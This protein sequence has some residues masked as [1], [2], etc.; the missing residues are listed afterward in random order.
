MEKLKTYAKKLEMKLSEYKSFVVFYALV[1]NFLGWVLALIQILTLRHHRISY[2]KRI[3]SSDVRHLKYIIDRLDEAGLKS[4][5]RRYSSEIIDKDGFIEYKTCDSLLFSSLY[6]ASGMNVNIKMAEDKL[7]P[8]RWYRR[9]IRHNQC[10][11]KYSKSTI[12]RDMLIGLMLGAFVRGEFDILLNLHRYGRKNLWLMGDGAFT[13]IHLGS[14]LESTLALCLMHPKF[15]SKFKGLQR[16][17]RVRIAISSWKPVTYGT[18]LKGY[19]KHLLTLHLILRILVNGGLQKAEIDA[20]VD[21]EWGHSDLLH[22]AVSTVWHTWKTTEPYLS[23]IIEK[24]P[25]DRLPTNEDFETKWLWEGNESFN[26]HH[27][28]N[29]HSGGDILFL[30]AVCLLLINLSNNEDGRS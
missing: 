23:Q 9:S 22:H 15:A 6:W 19:Q 16:K 3:H 1:M 21:E 25:K 18:N 24:Y 29:V 11:P 5:Y 30:H 13:R 10:Y 8:G 28:E 12:S 26:P 20:L 17:E 27:K 2:V 14:G 4:T 7:E